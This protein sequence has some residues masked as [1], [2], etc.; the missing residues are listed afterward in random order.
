MCIAAL[1]PP[2]LQ[3]GLQAASPSRR[4]VGFCKTFVILPGQ[5]STF[6]WPEP[7]T[8]RLLKNEVHNCFLSKRVPLDPLLIRSAGASKC[9][10]LLQGAPPPNEFGGIRAFSQPK[11]RFL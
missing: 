1:S 11:V 10:T 6:S 7:D 5:R 3:A 8:T 9:K 2:D 4:T